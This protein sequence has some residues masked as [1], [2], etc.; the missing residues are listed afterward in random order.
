M[1]KKLVTQFAKILVTTINDQN[2]SKSMFRTLKINDQFF[3][4]DKSMTK[5]LVNNDQKIG[6][7]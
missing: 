5:K 3:G 1:A 2:F 7:Q 4:H 6:D